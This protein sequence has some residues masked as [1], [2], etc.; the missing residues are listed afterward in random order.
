MG[1]TKLQIQEDKSVGLEHELNHAEYNKSEFDEQIDRLD[2]QLVGVY[3]DRIVQICTSTDEKWK[4][5]VILECR[6]KLINL[7][8]NK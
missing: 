1:R 5:E 3:I 8:K 2:V 4:A 6:N 7:I